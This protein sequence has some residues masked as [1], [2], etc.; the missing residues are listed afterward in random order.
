MHREDENNDAA[1]FANG[2]LDFLNRWLSSLTNSH[3]TLES[4]YEPW[5]ENIENLFYLSFLISTAIN[6][7]VNIS[8][9]SDSEVPENIAEFGEIQFLFVTS[10][11]TPFMLYHYFK[12]SIDFLR[13]LP[14]TILNYLPNTDVI[15]S[16]LPPLEDDENV[17]DPANTFY[18]SIMEDPLILRYFN[19]YNSNLNP[20]NNV[21]LHLNHEYIESFNLFSN[22]V[23]IN[24][25]NF[26]NSSFN[27]LH[28][29]SR[30]LSDMEPSNQ[31]NYEDIL[32][33]L[34]F[35]LSLI[36]GR[37]ICP[38]SQQIISD[39]PVSDSN[40]KIVFSEECLLRALASRKQHPI[41]RNFLNEA[42]LVKHYQLAAEIK[43]FV[44]RI[45]SSIQEFLKLDIEDQII[46]VN[47]IIYGFRSSMNYNFSLNTYLN[48][49]QKQ[50]S[51]NSLFFK[52]SR[53]ELKQVEQEDKQIELKSYCTLY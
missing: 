21:P 44:N 20:S 13:N 23:R 32:N 10:I 22:F 33:E 49:Y 30:N 31:Q 51:M 36:P 28:N 46:A 27:H 15:A 25:R 12:K 18:G 29:N 6:L 47:S 11:T 8:M 37:Y 50:N 48:F 4:M 17:L 45:Q 41:T 1:D 7:W 26:I 9:E 5:H 35:P 53:S 38:I 43:F 19:L 42:M 14:S 2:L 34:N 24:L 39:I 3:P 52:S 40:T 16:D